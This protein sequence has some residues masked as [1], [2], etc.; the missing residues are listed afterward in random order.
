MKDLKETSDLDGIWV[1]F[2]D[3]PSSV[4]VRFLNASYGP[5]IFLVTVPRYYPH[6]AP[7]VRCLEGGF[8]CDHFNASGEVIHQKLN[9]DW[10]ATSSLITVITILEE[11][12]LGF[13]DKYFTP[14]DEKEMAFAP[15]DA[16]E[17]DSVTL[18]DMF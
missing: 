13:G 16:V 5:S 17:H 4:I 7:L 9:T 6:N 1:E 11:I 3:I 2:A 10:F 18:S 15:C 12:R 14:G 8:T